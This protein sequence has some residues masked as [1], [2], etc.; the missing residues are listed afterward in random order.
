MVTANKLSANHAFSIASFDIGNPGGFEEGGYYDMGWGTLRLN[1]NANNIVPTT[2]EDRPYNIAL[3][4]LI[5][6]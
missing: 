3:L 6:F 1:F 5:S 4:P 2:S